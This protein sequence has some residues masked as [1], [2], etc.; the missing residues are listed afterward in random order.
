MA[1]RRWYEPDPDRPVVNLPPWYRALRLVVVLVA[2]L[3]AL[4]ILAR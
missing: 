3:T 4:W 1:E 2:L